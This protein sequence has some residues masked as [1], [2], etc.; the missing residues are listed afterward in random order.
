M[1]IA[2]GCIE[3]GVIEGGGV[4]PRTGYPTRPLKASYG[5]AIPCLFVPTHYNA[6]GRAG[7]EHAT[8]LAYT[9]YIDDVGRDM[10][11]TERLRLRDLAGRVVGE[12]SVISVE[13]LSAVG[14]VKILV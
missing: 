2:N 1:I 4:D 5:E 6:Q 12:F 7:A 14:Q 3:I 13:P 9:V 10:F 11:G 8:S